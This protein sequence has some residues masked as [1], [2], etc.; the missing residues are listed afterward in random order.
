MIDFKKIT[1]LILDVDGTLTDGAYYYSSLSH[2]I[3]DVTKRFYTRDW[4]AL[5]QVLQE[6]IRV[7]ILSQAGDNCILNRMKYLKEHARSVVW[8][9][10]FAKNQCECYVGIDN[11]CYF[12][13]NH[14]TLTPLRM[15]CKWENIAYI[16]DAESDLECM[17]KAYYTG[18]PN[19]AVSI[20]KEESNYICDAKGGYGAV[21]E[22]CMEI[23]K[24]R[25]DI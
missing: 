21:Y 20:I 4:Y 19:D 9:A 11:K 7:V 23:L 1:T 25:G 24:K 17:R 16:G 22:F 2:P 15:H 10:A 14:K 12:I 6:G 5:E 18:C 8:K 13:E 3:L